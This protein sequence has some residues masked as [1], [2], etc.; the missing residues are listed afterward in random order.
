MIRYVRSAVSELALDIETNLFHQAA[1]HGYEQ[2]GEETGD[3]PDVG[4]LIREKMVR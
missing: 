4:V 2:D 1:F 3:H